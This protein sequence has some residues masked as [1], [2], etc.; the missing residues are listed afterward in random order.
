ML[1]FIDTHSHID[2]EDFN[3]N[4]DEMLKQ[5]VDVGVNKII[6]PGVTQQDTF[7]ILNLT[8]KII[9]FIICEKIKNLVI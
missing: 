1:E 7:R 6:I 2:F 8:N 9:L 3:E 4:F 5:C